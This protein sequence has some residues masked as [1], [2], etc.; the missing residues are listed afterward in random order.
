VLTRHGLAS[1]NPLFVG[2]YALN[3]GDPDLGDLA[4][5]TGGGNQLDRNTW[6]VS[7]ATQGLTIMAE[8]NCWNPSTGPMITGIGSV[9]TD[10]ERDCGD[11]LTITLDG[12]EAPE[13]EP[14]STRT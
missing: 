2:V 14:A 1:A 5:G 3:S 6:D 8:D 7:N 10:P 13:P 9:D 12:D 4:Y 11:N